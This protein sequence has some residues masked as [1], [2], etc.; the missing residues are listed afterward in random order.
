MPNLTATLKFR[1]LGSKKVTRVR[2][3]RREISKT[4]IEEFQRE[5]KKNVAPEVNKK[6][7]EDKG[8]YR[9]QV[10][11]RI[12]KQLVSNLKTKNVS[13]NSLINIKNSVLSS[14]STG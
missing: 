13:L 7:V 1:V 3:D 10:T 11:V 14:L 2:I 6:N 4:A 12:D 9:V 8:P 5:L